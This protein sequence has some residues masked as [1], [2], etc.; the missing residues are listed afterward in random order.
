LAQAND[1]HAL[2]TADGLPGASFLEFRIPTG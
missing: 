2:R 1:R